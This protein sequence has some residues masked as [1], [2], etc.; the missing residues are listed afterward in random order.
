MTF[1]F[2]VNE[3]FDL[4]GVV[5]SNVVLKSG[6]SDTFGA[7]TGLSSVYVSVQLLSSDCIIHSKAN[8]SSTVH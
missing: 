7:F 8:P 1:D 3:M 6:Q 2:T 4:N 5:D